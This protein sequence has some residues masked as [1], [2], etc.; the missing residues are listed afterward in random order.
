MMLFAIER[1]KRFV[2]ENQQMLAEE[3]G[4]GLNGIH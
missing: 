3:R 4:R 1:L 2:S